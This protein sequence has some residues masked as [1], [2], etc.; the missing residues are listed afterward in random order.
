MIASRQIVVRDTTGEC[1]FDARIVS[2]R[3]EGRP[4]RS[5]ADDHESRVG[6]RQAHHSHRLDQAVDALPG[7]QPAHE[8]HVTTVLWHVDG[9]HRCRS[10]SIHV[11][12]IWHDLVVA[13]KVLRDGAP[14][15]VGDGK[16]DPDAPHQWREQSAVPAIPSVSV[17]AVCVKRCDH[18][19]CG[20]LEDKPWHQRH[21]RP[22]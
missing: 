3:G 10:E 14:R 9:S 12:T 2:G 22:R 16:A 7:L 5:L 15:S 21:E 6:D 19:D 4:I 1:D 17:L 8:Q 20:L 11:D 18:W 13:R